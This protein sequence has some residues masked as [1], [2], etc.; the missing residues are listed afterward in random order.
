MIPQ[1]RKFH[2]KYYRAENLTIIVTGLVDEKEVFK[3]L[4]NFEEKLL[5]NVRVCM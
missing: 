1:I 3:M 4:H 5:S 2:Q